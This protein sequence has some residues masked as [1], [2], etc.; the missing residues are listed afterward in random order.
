LQY[1][2][3][4]F[5]T[6]GVSMFIRSF[7]YTK[8]DGSSSNRVLVPM[9]MPGKFM[10]GID[11]T[12]LDTEQQAMY[13]AELMKAKDRHAMELAELEAKYDL[14]NRYRQFDPS[15]MTDVVTEEI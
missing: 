3:Y 14:R 11:I 5:D 10:S 7:T 12:E 15:R 4:F 13:L 1:N 9:V 2:N 6:K 8:A